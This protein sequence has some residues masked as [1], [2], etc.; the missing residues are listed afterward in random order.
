MQNLLK[1][2]GKRVRELRS[3]RNLTQEKLA[4]LSNLHSTYIG[5]I[6]RGERN[7]SLQ[8]IGRI[9]EA[10]GVEIEELFKGL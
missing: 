1:M 9:A 3:S 6:E 4:E 2:F 7:V 10:L 8:N 5:G